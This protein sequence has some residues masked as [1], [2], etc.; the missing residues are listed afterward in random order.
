MKWV[1]RLGAIWGLLGI[2]L[3]LGSAIYRMTLV[4]L[5]AFGYHFTLVQWGFLG[6]FL[7]LMLYFEGYRGFHLSFS[8]RVAARARYLSENPHI[9]HSLLAPVFCMGFFHATRRRM[10]TSSAVTLMIISLV[11]IV[12]GI[13]QP[14]RGI[15]DVGVVAGL[16]WGL[17]ALLVFAAMAFTSDGFEH[18]PEVPEWES[19][20]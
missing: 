5:N 9:G 6:V 18:P 3:L 19:G 20:Q 8:R 4:A 7:F 14:W 16:V 12:H 11:I 1:G 10:I 13:V 15:I 2:S 17:I